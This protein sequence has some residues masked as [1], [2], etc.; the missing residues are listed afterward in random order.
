MRVVVQKEDQ[1]VNRMDSAKASIFENQNKVGVE[2][3]LRVCLL[4]ISVERISK[5]VNEQALILYELFLLEVNN[6]VIR[7]V[8]RIQ[9]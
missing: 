1:N 2:I 4:K 6:L 8:I 9:N 7:K 3:V 5:T